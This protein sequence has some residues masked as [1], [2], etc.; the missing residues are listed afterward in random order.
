M[1]EKQFDVVGIGSALLDIT[2]NVSD[3]FLKELNLKKGEMRLIDEHESNYILKLISKHAEPLITPG[4]S[5]SNTIAG[6]SCFG[7][8]T[9]F[10]GKIGNDKHGELYEHKTKEFGVLPY[11]L[12]HEEKITG[13]AITFITPDGQRTFATHLGASAHFNKHD[14]TEDIIKNARILHLEGYQLENPFLRELLL[15]VAEL[16]A[17]HNVAI[18]LDCS[19]ASLIIRNHDFFKSFIKNYVDII[20]ANE[21]ESKSF[22]GKNPEQALHEIA[23]HVKTVIIK[24]GEKGS[25]IK[26]KNNMHTILPEKTVVVNTNGAGDM[27]AAA[28]LHSMVQNT[29]LESAGKLASFS[30]ALIVN[31]QGTRLTSEHLTKIKLLNPQKQLPNM[32]EVI[33]VSLEKKTEYKVKDISLAEFGRKEIEIAEKE[34]PGLMALRKK[35]GSLKPL[36]KIRISGSLHMTIQTAVLIETLQDL[37]ADVRWASCNI[38]STQDHAAAAIAK[39]GIPVFAWKEESLK[40]YW[41]CTKKALDFGND[42]GPQLI[43][44]DGGDATLLIHKG[45]EAEDNPA[46]L[47][48]DYS[49]EGEDFR[50]LMVCLKQ[51]YYEDKRFWHKRINDIRGVSEETTTGV[52]RLYQMLEENK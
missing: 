11:L 34:M 32:K 52:H 20:F 25:M 47:D 28:I 18:S 1:K 42:L 2:C 21:E 46:V 40:D 16:A 23:N 30:A 37:G 12:R 39:A 36:N 29:D 22:T 26:S 43:V 4:G 33:I 5:C 13:H 8:K 6:V 10:I 50:E 7:G 51:I 15:E 38:F 17:K 45:I 41:D 9:A 24:L 49:D 14:I 19:D 48:L 31:S 27:Y 35:Y 44:D 3:D